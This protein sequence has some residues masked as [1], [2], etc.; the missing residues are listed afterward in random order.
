MTAEQLNSA[1][2][3]EDVLICHKDIGRLVEKGMTEDEI[4]TSGQHC[5]GM[6]RYRTSVC[7]SLR[8]P[9]SNQFQRR[10]EEIADQPLI[11]PHKLLE[12]HGGDE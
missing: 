10:L 7:K 6:A 11:A 8:D 12:H 2:H 4:E 1:V 9:A 3:G 5:V